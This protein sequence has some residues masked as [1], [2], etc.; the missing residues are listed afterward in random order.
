TVDCGITSAEEVAYAQQLGFRVIITDHHQPSSEPGRIL[1]PMPW[2]THAR[3][4]ASLSI[5]AYP[6]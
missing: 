6:G 5:R 4:I 1:K 3:R 2:L